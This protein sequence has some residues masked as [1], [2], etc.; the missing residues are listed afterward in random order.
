[1]ILYLV[2]DFKRVML[3]LLTNCHL[4]IVLELNNLN[5]FPLYNSVS[6]EIYLYNYL[7]IFYNFCD[8]SISY[9]HYIFIFFYCF[10]F[11]TNTPFLFL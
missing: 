1:M 9:S 7:F 11:Y 4:V 5:F 8:N 3:K 2:P 6:K 10:D